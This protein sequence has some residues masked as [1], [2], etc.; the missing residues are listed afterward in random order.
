MTLIGMEKLI[1]D[2]HLDFPMIY[3][4]R[5]IMEDTD[6]VKAIYVKSHMNIV[7]RS[8]SNEAAGILN[9]M[10]IKPSDR[11]LAG[12]LTEFAQE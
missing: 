2:P 8:E 12:A 4:A 11:I 9:E 5:K 1:F 3:T 6:K 7:Y 10:E